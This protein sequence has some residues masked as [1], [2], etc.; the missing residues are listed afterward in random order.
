MS[1]QY[2]SRHDTAERG[3]PGIPSQQGRLCL[4][5]GATRLAA[6]SPWLGS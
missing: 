3:K 5:T 6:A 1:Q 4:T 2:Q